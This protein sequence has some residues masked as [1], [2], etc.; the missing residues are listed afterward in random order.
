MALFAP[1]VFFDVIPWPALRTRV[2][3]EAL[4]FVCLSGPMYGAPDNDC[5]GD[6]LNAENP[7]QEKTEDE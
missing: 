3:L 2:G 7:V 1:V 5:G 6:G 4:E